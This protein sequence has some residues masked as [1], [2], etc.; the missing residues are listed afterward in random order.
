MKR[1]EVTPSTPVYEELELATI[2]EEAILI[3][4][5]MMNEGVGVAMMDDG[6]EQT[7]ETEKSYE[8][9]IPVE[10]GKGNECVYAYQCFLHVE[11][12]TEIQ[13]SIEAKINN[14]EIKVIKWKGGV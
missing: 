4:D 9:S 5:E 6:H 13:W 11:C 14:M 7:N 8:I 10:F 3:E 12:Q 2:N 1:L